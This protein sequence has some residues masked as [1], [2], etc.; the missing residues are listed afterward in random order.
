MTPTRVVALLRAVNVGGRILR[1]TDLK[2]MLVEFGCVDPKTLLQS[3]NAVFGLTAPA[4]KVS[5]TTLEKKLEQALLAKSG[6]QSDVFVRTV[7]EW[8][9]AIAGNPFDE[10]RTTPARMVLVT[11]RDAPGAEAVK[12]LAAAIKGT[13][14]IHVEGRSLYVVYPDGQ[15]VSKFTNAVIER[16][17]GTRGT[18]RNWNTVLKL[19]ALL[20]Q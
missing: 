17:L 11:L 14:R 5:A 8:D 1:M 9:A 12:A 3:G 16:V 6:I 7:S 19:Q 15:G 4:A 20:S 10:A 18:A 2:D 13:E